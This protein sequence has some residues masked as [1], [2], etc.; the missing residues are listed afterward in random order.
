MI[1]IPK[2]KTVVDSVKFPYSFNDL[3]LD[4]RV[5]ANYISTKQPVNP[6]HG[7]L[8]SG[9]PPPKGLKTGLGIIM[10]CLD[11]TYN[12]VYSRF[13]SR[14]L[15]LAKKWDPSKIEAASIGMLLG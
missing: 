2:P 4:F 1:K 8:G 10:I 14:Q 9:N 13:V 5:Y 11:A 15:L 6:Y 7:G 3:S 12:S